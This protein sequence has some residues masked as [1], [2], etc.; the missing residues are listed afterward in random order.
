M[1]VQQVAKRNAETVGSTWSRGSVHC[2][3]SELPPNCYVA[4]ANP[5]FSTIYNVQRLN[6]SLVSAVLQSNLKLIKQLSSAWKKNDVLAGP[7]G[8]PVCLSD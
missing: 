4:S 7:N 2:E 5:K 6:Q 8:L 1:C 3:V